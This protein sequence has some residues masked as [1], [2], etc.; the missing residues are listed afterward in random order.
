MTCVSTAQVGDKKEIRVGVFPHKPFVYVGETGKAEG[1]FVD[2]LE[3]IAE[4]EDWKL[5]WV[6]GSWS[7]G[8]SRLENGTL[9][10]GNQCSIY[11]R[12]GSEVRLHGKQCLQP[13]DGG[14]FA[15]EFADSQLQWTC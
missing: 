13:L 5:I 12:K 14:L 4:K 15:S 11:R 9:D 3:D 7:E 6:D 1:F 2:L 8:L 10:V